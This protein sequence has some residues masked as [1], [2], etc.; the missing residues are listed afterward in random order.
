MNWNDGSFGPKL[1]ALLAEIDTYAARGERVSLMGS[2]AG[3][4]A[5]LNAY[6]ERSQAVTSVVC[7]SGK[8][9]RSENTC[10]VIRNQNPAFIESMGLLQSNL[11]K[12]TPSEKSRILSIHPLTDKTVATK[13]TIILGAHEQTIPVHGHAAAIG[14]GIIFD[15]PYISRFIKR[16]VFGYLEY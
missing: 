13:D 16:L 3:A 2:S 7:V 15:A 6:A 10:E 5:V 8:I 4:S 14:Y 12:F 11:A 9:N 1:A